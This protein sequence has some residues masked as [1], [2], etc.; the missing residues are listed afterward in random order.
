MDNEC[1]PVGQGRERVSLLGRGLLQR[2]PL[3]NC[4]TDVRTRCEAAAKLGDWSGNM[5]PS[6]DFPLRVSLFPSFVFCSRSPRPHSS[7]PLR[8]SEFFSRPAAEPLSFLVIAHNSAS[9]VGFYV[10]SM[11]Q[12]FALFHRT[13]NE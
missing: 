2:C 13:V 7:L 4:S 9:V 3:W 5:F 6:E 8:T 12:F 11:T 10:L 1:V